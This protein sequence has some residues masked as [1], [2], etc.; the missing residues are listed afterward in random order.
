MQGSASNHE[1]AGVGELCRLGG[2]Q[3]AYAASSPRACDAR[4]DALVHWITGG[5]ALA[6]GLRLRRRAPRASV[7]CRPDLRLPNHTRLTPN[8]QE[9]IDRHGLSGKVEEAI[10]ATVKAKPD[11]PLSFLVGGFC[12]SASNPKFSGKAK[13]TSMAACRGRGRC[14]RLA[15]CT[16]LRCV[17][18]RR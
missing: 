7:P 10:N 14:T 13:V 4:R 3:E 15:A 16:T 9:Y 11:E 18:W 2:W 6:L 5:P 8:T 12:V 1:R 17:A